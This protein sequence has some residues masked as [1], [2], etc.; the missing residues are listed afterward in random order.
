MTESE[1]LSLEAPAL[2][3]SPQDSALAEFAA[4]ACRRLA[5]GILGTTGSG[6]RAVIEAEVRALQAALGDSAELHGV[7][8]KHPPRFDRRGRVQVLTNPVMSHRNPLAPPLVH[9]HDGDESEFRVTLPLQ[10]QGPRNSLHGGYV[11]VLLD[12]VLWHAVRQMAAGVSFTR[13]LTIT[14]ERPVPLF[15]E[16]RIIGRVTTIEGRKTFAEGEI[17]AGEAVCARARGLWISPKS[18]A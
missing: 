16:L 4:A 17:I 2:P 11:A 13:E 8:A 5:G 12:D 18:S 15:E 1:T 6:L 10:Y 7:A 9:H 14:Y 3:E